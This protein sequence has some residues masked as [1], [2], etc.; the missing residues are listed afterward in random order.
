[1]ALQQFMNRQH[2]WSDINVCHMTSSPKLSHFSH[3]NVEKLGGSWGWGYCPILLYTIADTW[4]HSFSSWIKMCTDVVDLLKT[5]ALLKPENSL[6]LLTER[7]VVLSLCGLLSII[8]RHEQGKS[9]IT[10]GKQLA[11][12]IDIFTRGI[13]SLSSTK[14]SC[15][16]IQVWH[17]ASWESVCSPHTV[18]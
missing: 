9:N 17:Q 3:T 7:E 10:L 15:R 4:Y 5:V 11:E 6:P 13:Y 14:K 1:M 18:P 16:N 8:S 12:N 2:L